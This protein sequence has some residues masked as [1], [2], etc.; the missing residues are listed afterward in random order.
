M[1]SRVVLFAV[2]RVLSASLGYMPC[3]T[4]STGR[5][6]AQWSPPDAPCLRLRSGRTSPEQGSEQVSLAEQAK[7]STTESFW[8]EA[9]YAGFA[10]GGNVTTGMGGGP[11]DAEL[12]A[13]NRWAITR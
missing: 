6:R 4:T 2:L 7:P 9:F 13:G 5:S 12:A 3:S 1:G 11:D 10:S 8:L